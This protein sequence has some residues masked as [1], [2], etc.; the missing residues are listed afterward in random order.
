ML[1][2]E[3]H[4]GACDGISGQGQPQSSRTDSHRC[5]PLE[6]ER[7][8]ELESLRKKGSDHIAPGPSAHLAIPGFWERR[9]FWD[10]SLGVLKP[11]AAE[12]PKGGH[13][14]F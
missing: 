3:G 1:W 8:T 10:G 5:Q 6:S 11:S 7:D 13:Q 12:H 14:G 4:T 9:G 2:A